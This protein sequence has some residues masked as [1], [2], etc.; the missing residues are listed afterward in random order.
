MKW[1]V[2]VHDLNPHTKAVLKNLL[3]T[4]LWATSWVLIKFGLNEIPAL[5]FA[6]LRYFLAF[7][8]LVIIFARSNYR[9]EISTIT[10]IKWL[11]LSLL[12]ILL[13][14]LAQGAQ[15]MGLAF[16]PA[17]TVNLVLSFTTIF[18]AILSMM[19]ISE[20]PGVWQWVG[21]M[22]SLGGALVYFYPIEVSP[23]NQ[24]GWIAAILAMLANSISAVMGRSVNRSG[25]LSPLT[26]TVI[27]MG[28]GGTLLLLTGLFFQGL[29]E[30]SLASWLVIIW[31]AV[32]NTAFAFTL[33]N[34][35]LRVLSAAESSIIINS[36][37]IQIPIL[38]VVFLG[39]T[40]SRKQIFGLAAAIA[41]IVLVQLNSKK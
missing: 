3:V 28:I 38:A 13:Y 21:I 15:F 20:T 6:G 39:E 2:M 16:L 33:W 26:V 9:R 4:F 11:H 29:P 32:I 8:I 34:A 5:T 1:V 14:T 41:G 30:I 37:M 22:L 10:R 12:G 31:L 17:V 19:L 24:I 35:T 25:D 23:G 40:L 27:T 7:I 18:V 36:M